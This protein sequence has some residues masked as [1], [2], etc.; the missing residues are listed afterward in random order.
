MA[1]RQKI[2]TRGHNTNNYAEAT[3]RIMKDVVLQRQ[4]AF[5]I[6][7][8]VSFSTIVLSQYYEHRLLDCAYGR[9]QSFFVKHQKLEGCS[10]EV[11][12]ILYC[13]NDFFLARLKMK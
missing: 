7:A 5:N 1:F 13:L 11:C 4:K 6:V 2:V 9:N 10:Q 12:N 8:L 3:I